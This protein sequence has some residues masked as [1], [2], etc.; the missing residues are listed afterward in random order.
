MNR[1]FPSDFSVAMVDEH[2]SPSIDIT[3]RNVH[4][5]NVQSPSTVCNIAQDHFSKCTDAV[6]DR[7]KVRTYRKAISKGARTGRNEVDRGIV[8]GGL[9]DNIK[10]L[11]QKRHGSEQS[12]N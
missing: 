9:E 5:S 8:D 3:L 10:Q 4:R 12:A 6:A 1:V 2:H 11:A 7:G